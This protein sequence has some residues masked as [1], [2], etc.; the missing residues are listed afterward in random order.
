MP[1]TYILLAH[2][3]DLVYFTTWVPDTSNTSA[4]QVRQERYEY[5][6]NY[7]TARRVKNVYFDSDTSDNILSF[8]KI[9][10]SFSQTNLLSLIL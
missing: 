2:Y 9:L 10:F 6:T 1:K 4:T 5:D 7:A 8:L 3:V